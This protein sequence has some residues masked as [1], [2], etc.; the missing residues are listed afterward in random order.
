MTMRGLRIYPYVIYITKP[1]F[2]AN[3]DASMTRVSD[4]TRWSLKNGQRVRRQS[5]FLPEEEKADV[6]PLPLTWQVACVV[7]VNSS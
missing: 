6:L 2:K 5:R 3:N 1:G 4:N 7:V